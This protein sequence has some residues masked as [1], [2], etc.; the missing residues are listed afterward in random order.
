MTLALVLKCREP[1]YRLANGYIPY[2]PPSSGRQPAKAADSRQ[3]RTRN[4]PI[5]KFDK[6]SIND[7]YNK[8]TRTIYGQEAALKAVKAD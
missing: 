8:L 3:G 6:N 1:F 7:V 4:N 2:Q 5:D